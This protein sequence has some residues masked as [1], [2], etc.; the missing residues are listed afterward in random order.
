VLSIQN[1]SGVALCAFKTIAVLLDLCMKVGRKLIYTNWFEIFLFIGA[2]TYASCIY[3]ESK[4]FP[5]TFS[6]RIE[7]P[8]SALK[9]K[10]II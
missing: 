5:V 7:Q 4:A 3:D 6:M 9:I 1:V 8:F 10:M 2:E